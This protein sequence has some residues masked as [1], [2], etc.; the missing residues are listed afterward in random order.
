MGLQGQNVV[1][2]DEL[3]EGDIRTINTELRPQTSDHRE[4]PVRETRLDG[5]PRS[6]K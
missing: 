3:A 4:V 6:G 1:I 2:G 5:N